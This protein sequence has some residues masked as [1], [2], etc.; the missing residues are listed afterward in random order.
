MWSGGKGVAN[1]GWWNWWV[2]GRHVYVARS[3]LCDHC[4]GSRTSVR[5][6]IAIRLKHLE[7]MTHEEALAILHSRVRD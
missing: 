7:L 1:E 3:S 2:S 4:G 5:C 6:C